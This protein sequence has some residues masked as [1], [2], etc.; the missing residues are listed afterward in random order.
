MII[1][2]GKI[3]IRVHPYFWGIILLIGWMSTGSILPTILWAAVIFGSI[4]IHEYGHALTAVFFGQSAQIDLV[5]LGGLTQRRGPRLK[6]WQ[7]F[8]IVLNGPLAGL[9]LYLLASKLWQNSSFSHIPL[10]GYALQITAFINWYWTLFNLIP[11]QPMD[12]GRLVSIL[13]ENFFG[14]RG[15][16][17]ALFI[18]MVLAGVL[19]AFFFY[20]NFLFAGA[21]LFM[22]MFESHRNWRESLMMTHYDEKTDLQTLF[23]E[24][25]K[26][27]NLNRYEEA[28]KK[29]TQI[30]S[31][32][33]KGILYVA[34][35]QSTAE[36]L[37]S[38]GRYQEALDLLL[39]LENKLN[40]DS[41]SL[42]HHLLY[43]T[44][45]FR[46]A[47]EVGKKVYPLKPTYQTA[48]IN[49]FCHAHLGEVKP[50]IGWLQAAI[51]DGLPNVDEM[52]R[53]PEFDSIRQD[54]QFR[55]AFQ[56]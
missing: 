46:K 16:T 24:A 19:S 21:L 27:L 31:S 53:M 52:L 4:V 3:P 54:P 28:F 55:L 26:D 56:S 33:G 22:F 11:V 47:S 29:L 8:L 1:I 45:Q 35:T 5:A 49:A 2:P 25:K 23:K 41:L 40:P 10:I 7:E 39:P 43:K 30:R 34:A 48:L 18:S 51:R 13:L 50:A 9:V 14:Y 15:V 20:I 12:G 38:R 6:L 37:A 36:I 42:L 17:T 32:T 44:G